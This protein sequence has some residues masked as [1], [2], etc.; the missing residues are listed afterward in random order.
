MLAKE[1]NPSILESRFKFRDK[2]G[3]QPKLVLACETLFPSII[4]RNIIHQL[5]R[6]L[7]ILNTDDAQVTVP[8]DGDALL[9]WA[10]KILDKYQAVQ[11]VRK[12]QVSQ[13]TMGDVCWGTI[14]AQVLRAN[15]LCPASASSTTKLVWTVLSAKRFVGQAGGSRLGGVSFPVTDA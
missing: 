12:L 7:T 4:L 10:E 11:Q 3:N 14:L 2:R 9:S 6:V 5:C 15:K 13:C 1:G 8:P